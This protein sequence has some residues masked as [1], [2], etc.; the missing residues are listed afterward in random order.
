M[1]CI[2]TGGCGFVGINLVEYLLKLDHDVIAVD[3]LSVGSLSE[4]KE[5][6]D[7]Y[8]KFS[9]SNFDITDSDDKVYK[10]ADIIYHLAAM[11]GVRE[12]VLYPDVWFKN[13]IIGTFNVIES[14]RKNRIK[15]V[16]MASTGAAVGDAP[17]PISEDMHMKPISPY[18]ASKGCMELYT[19][20]YYNSYNMN[21]VSLRFSNV[22]G[23]HSTLKTSLVAKFIKKIING[24]EIHI[25]GNGEQTRDFIN[26]KDLIEAIYL[27]GSKNV[28]GEIFQ[29]C[30]GIEVSV[31][32]ITKMICDIMKEKGYEIPKINYVAPIIGDLFTNYAAN[33][34]AKMMLSWIPK[35]SLENGLRETIEW[36][37]RRK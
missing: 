20:A 6:C 15:N 3:N 30:T 9:F 5:T 10:G 22:Y 13:N 37:L 4:L 7:K 8:D 18:G 16:I 19:T 12:S 29:I 36:F 35:I 26:I 31:N 34:K 25:Y 23:P 24:E 32:E 17:P 11:S 27:S 1:K 2:V 28:G 21:I 33:K 14:A